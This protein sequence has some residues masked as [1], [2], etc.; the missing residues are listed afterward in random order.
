MITMSMMVQD[1]TLERNRRLAAACSNALVNNTACSE[2]V[3][4]NGIN[5][6]TQ[7]SSEN[8]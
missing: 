1:F 4:S 2:K 3:D 8:I 5:G 6:N 7:C